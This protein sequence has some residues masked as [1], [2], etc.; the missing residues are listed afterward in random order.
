[1]DFYKASL[2]DKSKHVETHAI[3]NALVK[4]N[5]KIN[6]I[7]F[8]KISL[9]HEIAKSF[10]ILNFFKDPGIHDKALDW[11]IITQTQ[12]FKSFYVL[13]LV[14][15]VPKKDIVVQYFDPIIVLQLLLFMIFN[16]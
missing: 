7:L 1:M 16:T 11:W 2:K 14:D 10:E 12:F 6:N 9:A 13:P 5:V 3:K 15:F 8:K 4:A